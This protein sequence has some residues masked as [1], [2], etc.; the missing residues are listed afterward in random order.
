VSAR[1]GFEVLFM[2]RDGDGHVLEGHA[3]AVE[4]GEAWG[5][6]YSVFVDS[7]WTTRS[8]HVVC[9][10]TLGTYEIRLAADGAGSWELDGRPAPM[11]DGC[12]DVDLE[13]S[14]CTN[15][16]P[17]RRLGLDVGEAADAPAA[18]IRATDL[19]VERLEQR[20]ARLPDDGNRIRFD[21]EGPAFA[22][23][24]VL[25]YDELGLVL[26]YPGLAERVA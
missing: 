23:R 15:T 17:V 26:D 3:A 7:S 11:L 14:A 25:V 18:Y 9:R 19:R 13:A 2:R 21:Y 8:A 10:S 20:Y 22:Y 6:R 1:D 24:D 16:L 12:L 4:D 5:L